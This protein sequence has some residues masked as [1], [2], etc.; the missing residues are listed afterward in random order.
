[1]DEIELHFEISTGVGDSRGREPKR[2]HIQRDSPPVIDFGRQRQPYFSHD[3]RP[4]VQR[5]VSV[6]PG[7]QW[8][9][10]PQLLL[11]ASGNC[12]HGSSAKFGGFALG[13]LRSQF[14]LPR[15]LLCT[16]GSIISCW[17]VPARW[18]NAGYS[19]ETGGKKE[20]EAIGRIRYK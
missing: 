14:H 16:W 13:S 17:T 5:G 19:W 11:S 18:G 6:L 10:G 1:M 9:F 7:F 12:V 3:L 15:F 2:T 8:K 20:L 4:H